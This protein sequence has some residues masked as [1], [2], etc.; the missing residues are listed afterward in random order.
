MC[1]S[2]EEY[3]RLS[4]YIKSI[5]NMDKEIRIVFNLIRRYYD[6]Y[7]T[8]EISKGDLI[9]FF[10]LQYPMHQDK[11]IYHEIISNMWDEKVS[12]DLIDDIVEHMV[13][14]HS[15]T[16][17]INT[18]IPVMHGQK[19][20]LV[21]QMNKKVEEFISIMKNPPVSDEASLIPC[22]MTTE[23]LVMQL[24]MNPGW[25][26]HIEALD[27]IIG[28]I[29]RQS[30][31]LI[32]AYVDS[33]KTSFALALAAAIAEQVKL[34]EHNILYCGNEEN[35]VRLCYRLTQAF[36]HFN[37]IEMKE[38][39][40]EA[41]AIKLTK[42]YE[43]IKVVDQIEQENQLISLIEEFEPIVVFIDL[44]G[45][46]NIRVGRK[47]KGI[48]Y[49]EQL[50]KFYRRIGNKYDCAV[51]GVAQGPGEIMDKKYLTLRDIYGS[52]VA[53]QRSL[54]WAIGIGRLLDDQYSNVRFINVP[55]NKLFDGENSQFSVYFDKYRCLWRAA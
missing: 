24:V 54:D 49:I 25:H 7:N 29:T 4:P 26:T 22:A 44:A 21:P 8:E 33:G 15:A 55:K 28:G 19:Y 6:K 48:D 13:E 27:A 47:E 3:I 41:E 32:Y 1:T 45:D 18:L 34:E 37:R 36:T 51:I 2:K 11:D 5:K 40:A 46:M 20:G 31:G 23:E 17:I 43:R 16:D 50:F 12:D 10:D 42:G 39:W 35:A 14:V 9:S 30:L 52:R 53:I 38:K